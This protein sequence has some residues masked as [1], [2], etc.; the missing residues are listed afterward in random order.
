MNKFHKIIITSALVG[1]AHFVQG[2]HTQAF[3]SVEGYYQE[4]MEL[5]DRQ[6]Y[7]AAQVAF[8]RY[9]N[10]IHDD[11]RT[12]DAQYYYAVSGLYLLH[13]NAEKLI[14]DFASAHPTHPKA[15]LAYFELGLFEFN[16]KHYDKAIAYLEKVPADRLDNQQL[17]EADFKLAYSYFTQ[18]KFDKA[19]VLFDRNKT[20][21]HNYVYASNYYAGYLASRNGDYASAKKDLRVA[22]KMNRTARWYLSCSL[23]YLTKKVIWTK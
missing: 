18:K 3:T 19:K 9:V 16:Q 15:S 10:L 4:G 1:S 11:A 6:K 5:F 22:E 14:L 8:A 23:K 7:G 2:Q 13:G 17:K 21:E 20:G 12:A